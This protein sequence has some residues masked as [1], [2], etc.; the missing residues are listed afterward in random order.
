M[1]NSIDFKCKAAV[2]FYG[3]VPTKGYA[4]TGSAELNIVPF[5]SVDNMMKL[6][7][8]GLNGS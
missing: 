3:M 8:S 7:P 5:V 6:S 2:L 4:M 1:S